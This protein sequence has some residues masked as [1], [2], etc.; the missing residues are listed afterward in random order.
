MNKKLG[1]LAI[2]VVAGLGALSVATLNPSAHAVPVTTQSAQT[3][4][5]ETADSSEAQDTTKADDPNGP[6]V[7]QTGQNETNN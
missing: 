6:N 7:E 4:A 5:K 2:P 1:L 3:S